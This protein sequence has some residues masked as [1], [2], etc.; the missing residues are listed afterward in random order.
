M[1][2]VTPTRRGYMPPRGQADPV[3]S[4]GA[5]GV[6]DWKLWDFE[7]VRPTEDRLSHYRISIRGAVDQ[8]M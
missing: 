5:W 4:G 8:A 3:T 2:I 1:L 7:G 6:L